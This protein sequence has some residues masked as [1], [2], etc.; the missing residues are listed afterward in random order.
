MPH[1]CGQPGRGGMAR[2]GRGTAATPEDGF[3]LVQDLPVG[4]LDV[5]TLDVAVVGEGLRER[6]RARCRY[7]R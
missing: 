4:G 3:E 1:G 2:G 7:P 6:G 5:S